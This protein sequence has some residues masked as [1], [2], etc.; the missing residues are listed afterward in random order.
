VRGSLLEVIG[1]MAVETGIS[2]LDLINTPP[3]ILD[4]MHRRLK[5]RADA[6]KKGRR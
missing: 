3:E 1:V 6:Q 5:D 2:P 4:I